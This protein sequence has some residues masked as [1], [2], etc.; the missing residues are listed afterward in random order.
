MYV[1]TFY[2][3]YGFSFKRKKS[4]NQKNYRFV[5]VLC[6]SIVLIDFI[7]AEVLN[8]S[9]CFKRRE[10]VTWGALEAEQVMSI[11]QGF[12]KCRCMHLLSVHAFTVKVQDLCGVILVS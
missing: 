12:H 3:H 7:V 8:V 9:L 10:L 4:S 11:A 6:V 2:Y 1:Q 5:A